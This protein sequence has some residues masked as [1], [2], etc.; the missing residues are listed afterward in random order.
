METVNKGAI[1]GDK[2]LQNYKCLKCE[3]FRI[4]LNYVSDHLSVLFQFS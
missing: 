2:L 1:F 4:V 3:I